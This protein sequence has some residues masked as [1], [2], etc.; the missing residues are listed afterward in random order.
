MRRSSCL[1]TRTGLPWIGRQCV[2]PL[3]VLTVCKPNSIQRQQ[4]FK[5]KKGPLLPCLTT[6]NDTPVTCVRRMLNH[7][8]ECSFS[9]GNIYRRYLTNLIKP[10]NR[11]DLA[12]KAISH[13]WGRH[14]RNTF[15]VYGPRLQSILIEYFE[16]SWIQG[17][18]VLDMSS[19]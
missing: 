10:L 16:F 13:H 5:W 6:P 12:L 9:F 17:K 11:I 8:N 3:K 2:G 7:R 4:S 18:T 19:Q 14:Y 1:Y 15:G